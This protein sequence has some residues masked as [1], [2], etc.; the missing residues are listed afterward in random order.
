MTKT[1]SIS[2]R[3]FAVAAASVAAVNAFPVHAA[4]REKG[5]D[6]PRR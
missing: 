6:N 2:R 1:I 3:Q 4:G 5:K